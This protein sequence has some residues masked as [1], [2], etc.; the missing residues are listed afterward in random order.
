MESAKNA[1][2]FQKLRCDKYLTLEVMMYVE[3]MEACKF[4]FSLNRQVRTFI[5]QNFIIIKNG[6]IN[7]GLITCNFDINDGLFEKFDKIEKFYF[8]AIKRIPENRILTIEIN[9]D[10]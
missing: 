7:K 5:Q 10:T 4:I 2:P 6:Y 3:Y 8:Q 9:I 1:F